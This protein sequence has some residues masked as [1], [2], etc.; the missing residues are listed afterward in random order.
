MC[1][2]LLFCGLF[3]CFFG[4]RFF[5]FSLF[6]FGFTAGAFVTYV[7]LVAGY[8]LS[9]EGDRDLI[10][11]RVTCFFYYFRQYIDGF[12]FWSNIWRLLGVLMVA[13]WSAMFFNIIFFY[14][15]RNVDL[16]YNVL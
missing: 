6:T 15:Q 16:M 9:F 5:K 7:A 11:T 8:S 4:H 2:L 12:W 3:L 1:A 14:S 13:I 10:S